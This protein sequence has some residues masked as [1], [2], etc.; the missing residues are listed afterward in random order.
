MA[1]NVITIK[2]KDGKQEYRLAYNR[3]ALIAMEEM[4]F[5]INDYKKCPVKSTSA[6]FYG[7]FMMHHPELSHDEIDEILSN[8][9]DTA[10][11]ITELLKLYS[12]AVSAIVSNDKESKNLTWGKN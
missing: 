5:N 4:G 10:G 7:A 1:N 3:K 6:V 2:S 8:V 12:D 11:L 9:S